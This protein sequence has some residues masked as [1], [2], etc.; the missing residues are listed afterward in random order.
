MDNI[1]YFE[2]R[3]EWHM[4][5]AFCVREGLTFKARHMPNDNQWS[6]QVELTGGY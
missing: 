2:D 4:M 3:D 5:I 6:Y 1:V